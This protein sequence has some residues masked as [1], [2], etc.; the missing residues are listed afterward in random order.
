MKSKRLLRFYFKADELDRALDNLILNYACR[1]ADCAKGGEFYAERII[2]LIG[3]KEGLSE[4]WHYL[5]GVISELKE[6][7]VQTLKSYAL[8]R[9]GIK[10]LDADSQ[11]RIKCAVIK[12]TRHARSLERYAE[13]VRLVGEYYCLM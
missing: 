13:G 11:K 6:D 9:F 12:F 5:E 1:S 4:L 7:E 2:V 3:A 8:L 10:K